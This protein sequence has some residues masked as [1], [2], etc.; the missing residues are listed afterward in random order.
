MKASR[1]GSRHFFYRLSQLSRYTQIGLHPIK[2]KAS[3]SRQF[4]L[5]LGFFLDTL[6]QLGGSKNK[7]SA[8]SRA[9][10]RTSCSEL[11][12]SVREVLQAS[13]ACLA[14]RFEQHGRSE[15]ESP[16]SRC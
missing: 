10:S 5:Y 13:T 7:T 15:E 16:I 14:T 2:L 1:A 11:P 9:E 4:P 8:P 3:I 6:G 12:L